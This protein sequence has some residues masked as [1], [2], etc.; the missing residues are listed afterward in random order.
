MNT[1]THSGGVQ[2]EEPPAKAA[3]VKAASVA[4]PV[5]PHAADWDDD[6]G[7]PR[8]GFRKYRAQIIVGVLTVGGLIAG[9][10][11]VASKNDGPAVQQAAPT[12]MYKIQ[13]P[14]TPPPPPPPPPE[15][16]VQKQEVVEAPEDAPEPEAAAAVVTATTGKANGTGMTI[17]AGNRRI[18]L[19]KRFG[20][21]SAA[22]GW[23][24][25][26]GGAQGRISDAMR[27]N[28]KT[29]KARFD[30]LVVHLWP[31][32]TGRITRATLSGST[33]DSTVDAAL[34]DEVLTGMMMPQPPPEG[35][36]LPINLR[37]QARRP[38]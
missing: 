31:D 33:G 9:W 11:A 27:S 30:Q 7:L 22:M 19:G 2:L 25:Y 6:D 3:P 26:A 32:A 20:E 18:D 12:T 37:L 24:R 16:V 23:K 5:N 21:E 28:P 8:S 4:A 17:G 35:M 15:Q 1:Q 34:R 29:R 13:P 36:P 38:N 10:K 14:V